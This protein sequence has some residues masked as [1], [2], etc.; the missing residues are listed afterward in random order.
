MID[1]FALL[2]QPRRPWLD[3][4]DLKQ[5]Y[6]QLTL[7]TH[8][9]QSGDRRTGPTFAAVNEAYRVLI[10]PKLRLQ[11]LLHLQGHT[12]TADQAIP[13]D[14]MEHFGQ[15]GTLVQKIDCLLAKLR[16]TNNALTKSLLRSDI[17]D[18]QKCAGDLL[19]QLK[20]LQNH[21]L[22]ELRILDEAWP[23]E[24]EV[25]LPQLAELYQRFAYLSRWTQ[26]LEERRFQLSIL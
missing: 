21:A 4:Q 12:P 6:Q 7:A 11:H 9:D 8:P 5:R 18:K 23:N 14:L 26:Q 1:Y 22:R 2:Q 17:L 3:S 25:A 24:R 15:I 19:D 16:E 20:E 10:N 13:A